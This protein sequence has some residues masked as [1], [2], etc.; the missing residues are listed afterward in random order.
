MNPQ[1]LRQITLETL[2]DFDANNTCM[3]VNEAADFLNMHRDTVIRN[4]EKGDI[5]AKLIGRTWRIP[6]L[7]FIEQ[8]I[9]KQ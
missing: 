5:K 2:R 1:E 4:I 9:E 6:K 3:T 7:Q 8:I